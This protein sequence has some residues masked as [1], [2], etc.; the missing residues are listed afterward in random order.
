MFVDETVQQQRIKICK[1]CE[2]YTTLN[3]CSKCNCFMPIKTKLAHKKC[4]LD[5]W[6]RVG[7]N[8]KPDK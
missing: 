5:K 3:F 6:S 1:S 7:L 2:H 4:P 8:Q